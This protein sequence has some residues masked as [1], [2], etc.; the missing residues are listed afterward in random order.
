MPACSG[1][2]PL[3]GVWSQQITRPENASSPHEISDI[4]YCTPIESRITAFD[5]KRMLVTTRLRVFPTR[6]VA[7]VHRYPKLSS[8]FLTSSAVRA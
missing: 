3:L 7:V 4:I 5:Y 8:W 2:S 6:R 1:V